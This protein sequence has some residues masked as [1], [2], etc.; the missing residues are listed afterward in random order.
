MAVELTTKGKDKKRS[1][2][3][4]IFG[5]GPLKPH[6]TLTKNRVFI[7]CPESFPFKHLLM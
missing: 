6:T 5:G 2:W 4:L 3:R 7:F 1:P